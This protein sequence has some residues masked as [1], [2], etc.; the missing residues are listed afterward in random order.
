MTTYTFIPRNQ[1]VRYSQIE[2]RADI[3]ENT[4]FI[5][6]RHKKTEQVIVNHIRYPKTKLSIE[7]KYSEEKPYISRIFLQTDDA[8]HKNKIKKDLNV[9]GFKLKR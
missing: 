5:L 1:Q 3:F 2:L 4:G 9:Q 6:D 8:C 7:R